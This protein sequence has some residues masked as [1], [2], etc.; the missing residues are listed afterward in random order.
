MFF[1]KL[2]NPTHPFE[3]IIKCLSI[4]EILEQLLVAIV[5]LLKLLKSSCPSIKGFFIFRLRIS[6]LFGHIQQ[7]GTNIF[8]ILLLQLLYQWSHPQVILFIFLINVLGVQS[9]PLS[10]LPLTLF[11]AL[12]ISQEV[13]DDA[14]GGNGGCGKMGFGRR[15]K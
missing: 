7:F 4:S 15:N 3:S 10:R 1:L 12:N 6:R 13:L 8:Q 9:S 5:L 11:L 14:G 2:V